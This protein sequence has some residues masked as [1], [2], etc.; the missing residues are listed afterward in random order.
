M[1]HKSSTDPAT[2]ILSEWKLQIEN[3]LKKQKTL[4]RLAVTLLQTPL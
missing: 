2:V 3:S 4:V 1:L